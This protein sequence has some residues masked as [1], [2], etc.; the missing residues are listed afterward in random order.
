M[1]VLTRLKTK[2]MENNV[3]TYEHKCRRCGKVTEIFYSERN[4]TTW[5]RFAEHMSD[6]VTTP[7]CEQCEV[8]ERHTIHDIISYSGP[9]GI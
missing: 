9:F 6:M 1:I 4:Q 5:L 8:C 2:A 3:L 7:R